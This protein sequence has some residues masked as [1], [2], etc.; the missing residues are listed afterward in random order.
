MERLLSMNHHDHG[1]RVLL[2]LISALPFAIVIIIYIVLAIVSKKH[3]KPF[4]FYRYFYWIFGVLSAAVS[5][6]GPLASRAHTDF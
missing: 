2:E 6:V 1:N 4:S 3:Y 5:V